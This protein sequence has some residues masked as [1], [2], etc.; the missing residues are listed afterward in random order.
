MRLSKEYPA[1]CIP[2]FDFF[3]RMQEGACCVGIPAASSDISRRIDTHDYIGK[4][5]ER[6]LVPI[7]GPEMI[8]ADIA[9]AKPRFTGRIAR[10]ILTVSHANYASVV[11]PK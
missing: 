3:A 8:A 1:R 2:R 10:A 5:L 9:L 7:A 4:I 6:Y 11:R